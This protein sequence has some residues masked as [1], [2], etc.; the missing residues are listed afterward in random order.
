MQTSSSSQCNGTEKLKKVLHIRNEGLSELGTLEELSVST[1]QSVEV[2]RHRFLSDC[3]VHGTETMILNVANAA[4]ESNC[5]RI[6][7]NFRQHI[8]LLTLSAT[9]K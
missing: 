4:D 6:S 5:L 1:H 2:I 3:L 8:T 9:R 7:A